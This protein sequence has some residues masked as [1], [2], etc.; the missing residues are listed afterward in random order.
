MG[1]SAAKAQR[2]PATDQDFWPHRKPKHRILL[3]GLYNVGKTTLLTNLAALADKDNFHTRENF[4]QTVAH[5]FSTELVE[6]SGLL[7]MVAFD[8]G[9]TDKL[10]PL[11]RHF[12]A[13]VTGLVF[14]V[15]ADDRECA[16][17]ARRELQYLLA[18]EELQGGTGAQPSGPGA[19]IGAP[20]L[21]LPLLVLV[22]KAD[23][24]DAMSPVEVDELLGLR[25][26]FASVG[27]GCGG[28]G[29]RG[30]CSAHGGARG[31][32]QLLSCSFREHRDGAID[33]GAWEG[34]RWLLGAADAEAAWGRNKREA[35][36]GAAT[37]TDAP[38]FLRR[39]T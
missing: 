39:R 25:E 21:P 19:G 20:A 30:D 36:D 15:G 2:K 31:A 14:V 4:G 34:L 9:G 37:R 3:L 8:M 23:A 11:L 1:N 16:A 27:A 18:N 28:G 17:D 10:R 13:G 29:A 12:F 32:Y 6:V 24:P 35:E 33:A 38:W 5:G 26:A 22:N 7:S